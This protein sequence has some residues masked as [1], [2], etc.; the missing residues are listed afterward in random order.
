VIVMVDTDAIE[1]I[2]FQLKPLKPRSGDLRE[3]IGQAMGVAAAEKAHPVPPL[4]KVHAQGRAAQKALAILKK[5]PFPAEVMDVV[6]YTLSPYAM[7]AGAMGPDA[8]FNYLGWVCA[9]QACLLVE[10]FSKKP[11]VST[12]FGN[13]HIITQ[14]IFTAVSGRHVSENAGL[15]KS[16]RAALAY[17]RSVV[18]INRSA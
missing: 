16:V 2:R 7:S 8:R 13:L 17:R 12:P 10:R 11:P 18:A 6:G 14:V 1:D 9:Y 5:A 15:L 3:A 4:S